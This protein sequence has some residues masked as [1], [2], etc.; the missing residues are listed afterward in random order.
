M[1]TEILRPNAT[2]DENTIPYD[3]PAIDN[4]DHWQHVD[5][6]IADDDDTFIQTY[7]QTWYRDLYNIPNSSVGAGTISHITVYARC[8]PRT[9]PDQTSVKIAIKSTNVHESAEK[10]LAEYKVWEDFSNQWATNPDTDNP[11]TW[12]EINSLQIG[13]AMR[14]STSTNGYTRFTQV[15]VIV[16]YTEAIAVGRSFGFIMG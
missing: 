12:G 9:I 4:D 16:D 8:L 3:D 14:S 11:W 15:Y 13:I 5:E 7:Y 2:G 6:A 10:Q 1:A